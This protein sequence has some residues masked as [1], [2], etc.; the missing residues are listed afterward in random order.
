[1][2]HEIVPCAQGQHNGPERAFQFYNKEKTDDISHLKT[3]NMEIWGKKLRISENASKG[4]L[5]FKP[6]N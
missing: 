4:I 5:L 1:M 2:N 3:G 6:M